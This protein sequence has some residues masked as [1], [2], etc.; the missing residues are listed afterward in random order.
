MADNPWMGVLRTNRHLEL[1]ALV[2]MDRF[3]PMTEM[4]Q[5]AGLAKTTGLL[6]TLMMRGCAAG[7]IEMETVRKGVHVKYLFRRT[8]A[9]PEAVSWTVQ[10]HERELSALGLD[11]DD[12]ETMRPKQQYRPATTGDIEL[13]RGLC[14]SV[15]TLGAMVANEGQYFVRGSQ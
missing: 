8:I 5:A 13:W 2:P 14:E 15:W 9:L 6:R 11:P 12:E 4:Y 7:V 3:A 10:E 1:V